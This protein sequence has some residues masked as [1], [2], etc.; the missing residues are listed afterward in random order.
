MLRICQ[1][2]EYKENQ[3]HKGR[4]YHLN[5][6]EGLIELFSGTGVALTELL[7]LWNAQSNQIEAED[8]DQNT[9]LGRL[10]KAVVFRKRPNHILQAT[11]LI[12]EIYLQMGQQVVP[13]WSNRA[14]LIHLSN[15]L[16]LDA[17]T[18]INMDLNASDL[19]IDGDTF[20]I[21]SDTRR[22]GLGHS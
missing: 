14:H 13:E 16:V 1:P 8:F 15:S 7:N 17:K 12:N 11:E 21:D 20:T 4:G 9:E 10:P 18:Q 6:S 5:H 2:P 19:Q 3:E 22:L